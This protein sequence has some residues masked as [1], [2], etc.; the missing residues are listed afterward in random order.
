[1]A[2]LEEIFFELDE[3]YYLPHHLF[4]YCAYAGAK[5]HTS[6]ADVR[7]YSAMVRAMEETKE[8]LGPIHTV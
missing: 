5:V 7:D 3:H 2:E 1:L 4:L 8:K 6:V